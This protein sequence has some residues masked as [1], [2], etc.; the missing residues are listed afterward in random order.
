[1]KRLVLLVATAFCAVVALIVL[2]PREKTVELSDLVWS[3]SP[4]AATYAFRLVNLTREEVSVVVELIAERSL[5]HRTGSKFDLAGQKRL[6][7]HL[8]AKE[9][10]KESGQIAL[11]SAAKGFLTVFPNITVKKPNQPLQPTRVFGPRG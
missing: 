3:E 4:G 11:A 10:K 7:I 5:E 9:E 6:E 1:M 2:R 8:A